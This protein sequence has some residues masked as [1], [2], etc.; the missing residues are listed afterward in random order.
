MTYGTTLRQLPTEGKAA[1]R[2]RE[3]VEKKLYNNKL[4][5]SFNEIYIYIY[6]YIYIISSE[7]RE[8]LS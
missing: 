4:A 6:I 2:N 7:L 8:K 1:L 3:N 5:I